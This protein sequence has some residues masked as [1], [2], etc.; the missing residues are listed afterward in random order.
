MKFA[1]QKKRIDES[2]S[3]H[4]IGNQ[5]LDIKDSAGRGIFRVNEDGEVV[6]WTKEVPNER[7]DGVATKNNE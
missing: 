4:F 3:F 1:K 2:T 7:A 5:M 6:A